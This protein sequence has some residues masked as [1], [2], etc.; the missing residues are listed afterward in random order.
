MKQCQRSSYNHKF[1][2]KQERQVFNN[3]LSILQT[4]ANNT[5][6]NQKRFLHC[7]KQSDVLSFT[8]S[9]EDQQNNSG[10]KR[11]LTLNFSI[12]PVSWPS[13]SQKYPESAFQNFATA[14]GRKYHQSS[15]IKLSNPFLSKTFFRIR[16]Y[17]FKI[18][19]CVSCISLR[20]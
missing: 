8:R 13:L 9:T 10:T 19:F 14:S 11:Q 18:L 5:L 12:Q 17:S 3:H 6:L 15:S 20:I 1:V 16:K 4:T 7:F 2:G